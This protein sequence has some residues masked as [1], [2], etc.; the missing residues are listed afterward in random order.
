M[1]DSELMTVEKGEWKR[2]F[3]LY[4]AHWDYEQTGSVQSRERLH[5]AFKKCDEYFLSGARLGRPTTKKSGIE[6]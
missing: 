1:R 2:L 3:D 6:Q 5:R 4:N